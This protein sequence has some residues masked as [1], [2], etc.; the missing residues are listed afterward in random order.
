M[1]GGGAYAD[2][3]KKYKEVAGFTVISIEKYPEPRMADLV[4]KRYAVDRRDVEGIIEVV[5]KEKIDGIFVGS[6]EEYVS[7]AIDI[8]EKTNARFYVNR[9]QW[10]I[11]SNKAR[12]KEFARKSGFPVIPEYQL[13]E[14]PTKEEIESLDYPVMIKPVDGSGGRGLNPCYS[15][16]TFMDLY[17]EAL[18]WSPNKTIIVEKLVEDAEDICVC[19]TLQ[20]GEC[21][22]SYSFSKEVVISENN[23]VSLPIFHIYPSEFQEQYF[24]EADEAAKKMI[25]EMGLKNGTLNIQGFY[26]N[27]KFMFYEAGYRMGG[28][29]AYIITD[30]MNGANVLN[31][32]L[33]YVLSGQMSDRPLNQVENARFKYPACNYYVELKAGTIDHI[34]GYEEVKAMPGVL[35]ITQMC[36]PGDEI[37]ENNQIGRAVYRIHVVGDNVEYLAERLV[38]IS[39]TLRIMSTTGEE[40]QIEHLTYER[41]LTAIKKNIKNMRNTCNVLKINRKPVWGGYKLAA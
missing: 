8:C 9:E 13:S 7:K 12:F 3:I 21:I 15:V 23:Y 10:D 33:N 2:H 11:I 18:R 6:S 40:M 34:E 20:D 22:L 27:G 39:N 31:Y 29:Q 30:Y 25:K 16:D 28:A 41:C 26:R 37:I 35:N 24:K 38:N 5:K 14:I 36:Y 19:Y 32:M 1:I 4:D 17:N